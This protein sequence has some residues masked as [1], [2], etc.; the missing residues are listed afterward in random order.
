MVRA[1]QQ[2]PCCESADSDSAQGKLTSPTDDD[3]ASVRL[4]GSWLKTT[5]TRSANG[6]GQRGAPAGP[7]PLSWCR[8]REGVARPVLRCGLCATEENFHLRI[9]RVMW[10][11][12]ATDGL[13]R[14]TSGSSAEQARAPAAHCASALGVRA[15]TCARLH[16]H[17]RVCANGAERM[18]ACVPLCESSGKIAR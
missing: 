7:A 18:C 5:T 11:A 10:P 6:G 1:S 9:G 13:G 8:A 3:A 12:A 14:R 15:Q 4:T 2:P 17:V 16:L